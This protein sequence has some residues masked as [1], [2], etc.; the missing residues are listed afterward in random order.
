[1]KALLKISIQVVQKLL[2]QLSLAS[3]FWTPVVVASDPPPSGEAKA[4]PVAVDYKKQD[5]QDLAIEVQTLKGKIKAKKDAIKKLMQS[6]GLSAKHFAEEEAEVAGQHG[7]PSDKKEDKEGDSKPPVSH[8]PPGAPSESVF[9]LV[10]S[11]YRELLSLIKTYEQKRTVFKYR[12]PEF[13]RAIDRQ[14]RRVESTTLDGIE[15]EEG[16]DAHISRITQNEQQD[17]GE[18]PQ[19]RTPANEQSPDLKDGPFDEPI[20]F[21][22]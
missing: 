18:K 16:L 21:S 8:G 3:V 20:V 14:Y 1:M 2:V 13:G 19:R 22:R 12:Y 17:F 15:A 9:T 10:Q 5:M 6:A 4:P 7:G 11:E